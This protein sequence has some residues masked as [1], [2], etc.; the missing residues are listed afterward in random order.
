MFIFLPV[1]LSIYSLTPKY[2]RSYALPLIGSLFY[3][4][5]NLNNLAALLAMPIIVGAVM[6]SVELYR[7][8]RSRTGLNICRVAAM[9]SIFGVLVLR[10]ITKSGITSGIGLVFCLMSAVSICTDVLRGQGRVPDSAWD[11]A[12]Y[13]TFFPVMLVGPFIK[14]G[15]FVEKTD[16]L[17]YSVE[18]FTSGAVSFVVGALKCIAVSAVLSEAHDNL[19]V[20]LGGDLS[21]LT[22]LILVAI[23]GLRIY[24]FLSGYSD[25]ARGLSSMLGIR[26]ER[27]CK[28]CFSNA[29]P[30][31][32]IRNFLSSLLDFC[33]SYITVPVSDI[34]SGLS[35]NFVAAVFAAFFYALLFATN[36]ETVY[37]VMVPFSAAMLLIVFRTG[38]KRRRVSRTLRI[39][40][41]IASFLTVSTVLWYVELGGPDNMVRILDVVLSNPALHVPTHALAVLG[42]AKYIIIP[43]TAGVGTKLAEILFRRDNE[44]LDMRQSAEPGEEKVAAPADGRIRIALKYLSAI[45]LL[46]AFCFAIMILLPQ[47]P[48]LAS[49]SFFFPF[50]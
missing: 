45:F 15:D 20:A 50:I 49:S 28:G 48:K 17:D 2:M 9:V 41:G 38:K 19:S 35:G 1:M 23:H 37:T 30:C 16:K 40:G 31:E 6:A 25:M 5:V 8:R 24:F 44:Y 33:R 7:R 34:V 26:I 3:A 11:V 27:D 10:I 22:A 46:A 29:T 32:C 14:Y 36:M 18:G 12:V 13:M 39:I 42:D 47:Y 21:V 43:L 4:A